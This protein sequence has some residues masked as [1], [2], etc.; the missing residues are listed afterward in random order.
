MIRD[1][2]P[3]SEDVAKLVL[4][5]V[6]VKDTATKITDVPFNVG[7]AEYAQNLLENVRVHPTGKMQC[8]S[9]EITKRLCL[10]V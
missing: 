1:H 7:N 4:N 8:N 2:A 3:S 5:L 10:D 9:F 6:R